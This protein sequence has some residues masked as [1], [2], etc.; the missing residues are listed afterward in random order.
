MLTAPIVQTISK[1]NH[2]LKIFKKRLAYQVSGTTWHTDVCNNG[3]KYA[4]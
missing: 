4:A 3:E 2:D 1:L